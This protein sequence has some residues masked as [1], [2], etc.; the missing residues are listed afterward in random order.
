MRT[1][2]Y[3]FIFIIPSAA[4]TA[5][6]QTSEYTYVGKLNDNGKP[7]NATCEVQFS[8]YDNAIA[9]ELTSAP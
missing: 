6:A 3:Q 1:T 4:T 7:A 9:G 5:V 8:L 2:L